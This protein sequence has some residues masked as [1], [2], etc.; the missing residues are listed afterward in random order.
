MRPSD[1]ICCAI[2]REIHD[3]ETVAIGLATTLPFNGIMLARRTHA[4]N[5]RIGYAVGHGMMNHPRPASILWNEKLTMDRAERL[6]SFGESVF[7]WLPARHPKEFFRPAQIDPRGTTNN[8]RVGTLRLP[9]PAGLPDVTPYH[10]NLYYYVPM[11]TPKAF[12]P[13]VEFVSGTA[14]G[15]F[16]PRRLVTGICAFDFEDGRMRLTTLAPGVPRGQVLGS[17]GFE[18]AVREPLEVWEPPADWLRL[19]REI[20]PLETRELEFLSGDERLDRL[21]GILR[22]EMNPPL[23]PDV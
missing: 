23:R 11:P 1:W 15:E 4:P 5:L 18:P 21:E 7:E 12:V 20:D 8:V 6:W 13:K 19:L 9:G 14:H 10:S 3:G 2:A 22:A 16:G 17:M